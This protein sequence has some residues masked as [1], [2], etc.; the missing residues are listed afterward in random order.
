MHLLAYALVGQ[1]ADPF[2]GSPP[3]PLA[4]VSASIVLGWACV[5][6][7]S[8]ERATKVFYARGD[9]ELIMSSLYALTTVMSL[10]MAAVALT[11]IALALVMVL[12]FVNVLALMGG[13]RWFA[14]Y[15]LPIAAALSATATALLATVALF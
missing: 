3:P 6:S 2:A 11:M 9:L 7:Q 1:A 12:P 8:F 5:L 14:T 13:A 4:V 10:R 15:G